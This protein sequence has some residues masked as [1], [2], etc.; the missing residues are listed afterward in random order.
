MADGV[1]VTGLR[2]TVRG[3]ERAGVEVNDLKDAMGSVAAEGA[4]LVRGF[5]PVRTGRLAATVRG[6]RAKNKAV[7]T[8]GSKRVPWAGPQ[9]YGWA[10]KGIKA[11]QFMQRGDKSLQPR[12][13][14]LLEQGLEDAVRKAGIHG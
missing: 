7:V 10:R 12:A 6:N 3:L 9:N 2:E 13:V 1:Y 4:R 14:K 5:T 11:K 8:A